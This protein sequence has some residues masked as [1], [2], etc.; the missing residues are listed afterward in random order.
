MGVLV[1][2]DPDSFVEYI[3]LRWI[4]LSKTELS[5]D[6]VMVCLHRICTIR[7]YS[8]K[9]W[10][11]VRLGANLSAARKKMK[12]QIFV[13]SSWYWIL[14]VCFWDRVSL[15]SFDCPGTHQTGL[16]LTETLNRLCLLS[17]STKGSHHC[18]EALNS[19]RRVFWTVCQG[20]TFLECF[21]LACVVTCHPWVGR[22]GLSL[23]RYFPSSP[24]TGNRQQASLSQDLMVLINK[25]K[26]S[27]PDFSMSFLFRAT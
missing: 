21:N 20:V 27:H 16:E 23:G 7:V 17:S 2:F 3:Y 10:Y 13:P 19:Y 11:K 22:S 9:S 18:L 6:G 25:T 12:W 5:K 26:H 1:T 24:P 8:H 15:S 14:S 4:A